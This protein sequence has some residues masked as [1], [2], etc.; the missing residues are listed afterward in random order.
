M[1][2]IHWP[3]V[4][5][6]ML[7][8]RAVDPLEETELVPGGKVTISFRRAGMN[9]HRCS[10]A[11]LRKYTIKDQPNTNDRV[12]RASQIALSLGH[13]NRSSTPAANR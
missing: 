12:I 1:S 8:S 2:N 10:L 5:R 6:L 7:T 9:W 4:A 11:S 13:I 3:D